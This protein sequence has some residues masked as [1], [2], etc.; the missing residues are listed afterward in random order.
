MD[1]TP[2]QNNKLEIC[3]KITDKIYLGNYKTS[4]SKVTLN[5]HKI[6]H[7]L[8]V[9]NEIKP[10]FI[11]SY[12]T[13]KLDV[14]DT[15]DED[16]LSQFDSVINFIDSAIENGSI[17]IHCYGGISRSPTII[18][19]Y[20]IK[21]HNKTFEHAFNLLKELKPDIEPNEGFIEKLKLLDKMN[22]RLLEFTYKCTVCR[23]TLFDDTDINFQHEYTPKKNYSYKRF[24]KSFVNTS[25]CSSYFL[26]TLE[27]LDTEDDI[28]GKINCPGKNV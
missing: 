19:A 4:I 14:T 17:L 27:F 20:L 5:H 10:L 23:R 26:N 18:I 6:T 8:C 28:G 9:A 21:K 2:P 3:V 7:I 16:I 24:K 1:S 11:D 22:N 25:E 12:N 13:M 15:E